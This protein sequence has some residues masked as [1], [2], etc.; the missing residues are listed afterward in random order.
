VISKRISARLATS[1]FI[2]TPLVMPPSHDANSRPRLAISV[3]QAR[4][5]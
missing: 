5:P 2:V 3:R 4:R 1:A